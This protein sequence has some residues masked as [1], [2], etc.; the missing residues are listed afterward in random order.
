MAAATRRL[1][2]VATMSTSFYPPFMLARLCTTLDHIARG[3]FGWNIVTIGRGRVRPTT[4]AWTKLSPREV[5]YDMADEYLD[6]VCQLWDS[7]EPDAIVLDRET[8]TYADTRRCDEI[9]FVGKYFKCRGP[10]NTVRSPQGKP[11]FVQ[12][13]GSPNGRD[14]AAK[15]AD[16]IIAP[17]PGSRA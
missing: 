14:F 11:T 6:L 2:V 4:S 13:G 15:H 10:L 7:W 17:P 9:N 16:S 3:R 8:G 5:R 1:G 12:A